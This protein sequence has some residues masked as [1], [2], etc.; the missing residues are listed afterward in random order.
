[1]TADPSTPTT[2]PRR[3][4]T[5]MSGITA[6]GTWLPAA[7]RRLCTPRRL[8]RLS[9]APVAADHEQFGIA[10]QLVEDL[11]R[12]TVLERGDDLE[13]RVDL[14]GG[15]H[16][17]V[18]GPLR[19]RLGGRHELGVAFRLDGRVDHVHDVQP[20][21]P[22][23]SPVGRPPHRVQTGLR[24]RAHTDDDLTH[25][26]PLHTHDPADVAAKP[27]PCG[28]ASA[29]RSFVARMISQKAH[30]RHDQPQPARGVF[31]RRPAPEA[32]T[33]G[34]RRSAASARTPRPARPA[35]RAAPRR[36]RPR[37]R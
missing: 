27:E 32:R 7:M 16:A 3:P 4:A 29:R 20:R 22:H 13:V 6:T 21:G 19:L 23:R 28:G 12:R 11:G 15:G 25:D 33:A 10:R 36:R 37:R 34:S 14:L 9:A 1:M 35:T 2:T 5:S 31:S 24:G 8:G 17:R 18:D 26:D 30:R